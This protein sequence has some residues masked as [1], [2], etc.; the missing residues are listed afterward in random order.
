MEAFGEGQES[1]ID[2]FLQL[3][4]YF[5][6]IPLA[7]RPHIVEIAPASW[8]WDKGLLAEEEVEIA[9][10]V[11]VVLF[12]DIGQVDLIVELLSCILDL[13]SPSLTICEKT[14]P[15]LGLNEIFIELANW[16]PKVAG[17]TGVK[18]CPPGLSIGDGDGK[19][20]IPRSL[21][22]FPL[23][24][25]EIGPETSSDALV[26]KVVRVNNP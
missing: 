11:E 9:E 1:L 15:F 12:D 6:S 5:M 23:K 21:L 13:K 19:T 4:A 8:P 20:N 24:K 7:L 16:A 25:K 3:L 22:L 17:P 10:G 18:I 26:H 14:P 2:P